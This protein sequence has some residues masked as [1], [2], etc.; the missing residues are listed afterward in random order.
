MRG[1]VGMWGLGEMGSF[2]NSPPIPK[3]QRCGNT[4]GVNKAWQWGHQERIRFAT[5]DYE[6]GE[7]S[8]TSYLPPRKAPSPARRRRCW[9]WPMATGRTTRRW[10]KQTMR[11]RPHLAIEGSESSSSWTVSPNSSTCYYSDLQIYILKDCVVGRSIANWGFCYG[12][13][14]LYC[15]CSNQLVRREVLWDDAVLSGYFILVQFGDG[16]FCICMECLMFSVGLCTPFVAI[17]NNTSW[18]PELAVMYSWLPEAVSITIS[19]FCLS[20]KK[21]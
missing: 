8:W 21:S 7:N 16:F 4:L 13:P 14:E 5:C 3:P 17:K 6:L 1:N 9:P 20:E 15:S 10:L 19:T 2:T 12:N 18:L 11:A